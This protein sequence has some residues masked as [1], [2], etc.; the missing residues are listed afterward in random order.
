MQSFNI[1]VSFECN[2]SIVFARFSPFVAPLIK[3]GCSELYDKAKF[4]I[5]SK[6]HT[7]AIDLIRQH[8]IIPKKDLKTQVTYIDDKMIFSIRHIYSDT[9]ILS[10]WF[11]PIGRFSDGKQP[12]S[13]T[14]VII[15]KIYLYNVYHQP[16]AKVC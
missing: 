11:Q 2:F 3:H 13:K 14:A 6:L 4:Q 5:Y 15:S 10:Y 16:I 8:L 1:S 9:I 12:S 7:L